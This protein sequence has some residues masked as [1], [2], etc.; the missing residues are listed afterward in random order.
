[1]LHWLPPTTKLQMAKHFVVLLT[2]DEE[3]EVSLMEKAHNKWTFLCRPK[4]EISRS[5]INLAER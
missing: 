5:Y 3:A 4:L 2:G 1:M